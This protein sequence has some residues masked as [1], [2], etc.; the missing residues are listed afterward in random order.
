MAKK[1]PVGDGPLW[2]WT[3]IPHTRLP[4]LVVVRVKCIERSHDVAANFYR[5]FKRQ[6][7][8][9]SPDRNGEMHVASSADGPFEGAHQAQPLEGALNVSP[10][11]LYIREVHGRC[12]F[13]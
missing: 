9:A 8:I 6:Y 7:F 2:L 12:L 13:G 4:G 5:P 10:A 3:N 11:L 1:M